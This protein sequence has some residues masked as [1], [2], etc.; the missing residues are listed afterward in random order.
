M[1]EPVDVKKA[2]IAPLTPV[3]W[4]KTI[5]YGLG[6]LAL[7]FIGY[8]V[9]KAYFKK[10]PPPPPAQTYTV[11]PGA[12]MTTAN[13]YYNNTSSKKAW[14]IFTEPYFGVDTEN[15]GYVGIRAGYRW[16]Y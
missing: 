8:G 11:Q 5:M 2:L 16:E 4:V 14:V 15:H 12:N 9:Y 6:L 1:A 3:Y 7:L 10:L 13:Y